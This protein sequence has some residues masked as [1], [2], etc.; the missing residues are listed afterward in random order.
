MDVQ[1]LDSMLSQYETI[2]TGGITTV[3]GYAVGTLW[4]L[5]GIDFVL[6]VL[7]NL[8]DGDH[9]KNLLSKILKYGFGFW[10]V[11]NY[12]ELVD[13]ILD[14]LTTVGFSVGGGIGKEIIK[15]PSKILDQGMNISSPYLDKQTSM[16]LFFSNAGINFFVL[17]SILAVLIAFIDSGDSSMRNIH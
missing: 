17:I 7:L 14:S 8:Q 16:E 2:F 4:L 11:D 15:N 10:I 13:I 12:G 1:I 3:H 9:L 5:I 6:S